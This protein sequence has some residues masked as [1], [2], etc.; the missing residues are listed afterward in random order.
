M[1]FRSCNKCQNPN[2]KW[3]SNTT[4]CTDDRQ[5]MTDNRRQTFRRQTQSSLLNLP[6]LR[7]IDN[8]GQLNTSW[9]FAIATISA[10]QELRRIDNPDSPIHLFI[11]LPIHLF[12]FVPYAF[13]PVAFLPAPSRSALSSLRVWASGSKTRPRGIVEGPTPQLLNSLTPQL[14][15]V[16]LPI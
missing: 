10:H 13:L 7:S 11:S 14:I 1:E 5:Q 15:Y 16:F 8:N 4:D 12:T 6:V 2:V 9:F 3:M